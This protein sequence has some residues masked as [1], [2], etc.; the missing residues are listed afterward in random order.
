MVKATLLYRQQ[1]FTLAELSI[2]LIIIGFIIAGAAASQSLIKQAQLRSI[3]SE[4]DTFRTAIN[5]F[6]MRYNALPGDITN[7]SDF[8]GT[9]CA[10]TLSDCNG[11]GDG[12][13]TFGLVD[14]NFGN[15]TNHNE[16]Y[17]AWQHLTLSGILPGSYSG[18]STIDA[19]QPDL[20]VNIPRSKYPGAGYKITSF[21]STY[22]TRIDFREYAT[23]PTQSVPG[24]ILTPAEAYALDLKMDD[25][26]A[27][28]GAVWGHVGTNCYSLVSGVNQYNLSLDSLNCKMAFLLEAN[29][30]R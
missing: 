21:G 12:Q 16:S 22:G 17:R 9:N 8:W 5:D 28:A 25:G 2:V 3:I 19:L 15:N 26:L 7:A 29:E 11:N 27:R 30:E 14:G 10:A 6:K 18:F 4:V 1:G 24:G 23:D 20:G 13:V